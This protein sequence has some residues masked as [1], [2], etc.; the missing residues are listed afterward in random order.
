MPLFHGKSNKDFTHNLK[1]EMHEGKPLKQSLAISYALKRR[2]QKEAK[3][4][5]MCA[6]GGPMKCESGCYAEGGDTGM[7][8]TGTGVHE[9]NHDRGS[10]AGSFSRAAVKGNT[11]IPKEKLNS[12]AKEEHQRVLGEMRADKGD[13]KYMA[14]G[15][16]L[17]DD[18]Y[19]P[20]H[21]VKVDGD[22]A[23]HE[24]D[25]YDQE[26][27]NKKHPMHAD[28]MAMEEDARKLNEHGE[29]EE[30][31]QGEYMA[32]GGQITDNHQD[33]EHEEDMVGRIM[34][35][36]QMMFSKGGR[37]AN[38]TGI[39]AGFEPNEFDDLHL[40]DDLEQ[41]DTGANSGDEL[42]NEGEDQRREDMVSRIM[43]ARRMKAGHNP[44]PA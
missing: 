27:Y 23:D 39:T 44:R 4:G 34:K 8:A 14:E 29:I 41:H 7:R 3:G 38:D 22:F 36:R 35:Q 40:R 32:E 19:Q 15:G 9:A 25:E 33:E 20:E 24:K 10:A 26:E 2:G 12:W 18:G 11:S 16:M 43:R 30:G 28:E 5:E 1:T 31:P 13:R 21:I 17:T 6:H 37:V 42:S